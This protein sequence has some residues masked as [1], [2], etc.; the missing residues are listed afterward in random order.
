MTGENMQVIQKPFSAKN[1]AIKLRRALEQTD[2]LR[3][4]NQELG[5][6]ERTL[7]C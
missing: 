3:T 2:S 4:E 5:L 7:N 1:L 6:E